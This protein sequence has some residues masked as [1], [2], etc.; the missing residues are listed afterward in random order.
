MEL[1]QNTEF[2]Q[3]SNFDGIPKKPT[4]P[5][6]MQQFKTGPPRRTAAEAKKGPYADRPAH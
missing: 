1:Q 4:F 2:Q 6:Y 3:K 5:L